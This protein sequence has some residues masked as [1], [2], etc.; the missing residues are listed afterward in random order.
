MATRCFRNLGA[1][2]DLCKNIIL[3]IIVMDGPELLQALHSRGCVLQGQDFVLK[4][5]TVSPF[6]INLRSL[7]SFPDVMSLIAHELWKHATC[8]LEEVPDFI[9]GVAH[10][11]VPI[12]TVMSTYY[13]VPMLSVQKDSKAYGASQPIEGKYS[14]GQSCIVVEDVVNT[15]SSLIRCKSTLEA[16]GIRVIKEICI[17]CRGE[18]ACSSLL[19]CGEGDG[20]IFTWRCGRTGRVIQYPTSSATSSVVTN[21]DAEGPSKML[22]D[23]I[24]KKGRL[25]VAADYRNA[26]DILS[27]ADDVGPYISVF[28]VHADTVVD[29]SEAFRNKLREKALIH[30]FFIMEDRKIADIGMI[31]R[32]QLE[33]YSWAHLVT[34]HALA[35]PS[36]FTALAPVIISKFTNIIGIV[37]VVE[38]SCKGALGDAR[39]FNLATNCAEN[40]K[41]IVAAVVAQQR[42]GSLPLMMPGV[43]TGDAHGQ[44]ARPYTDDSLNCADIVIVGRA[45]TGSENPKRACK[46]IYLHLKSLKQTF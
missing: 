1:F 10:G 18:Y 2:D 13:R 23:K 27:L 8:D 35:G 36:I 46:E 37:V 16:C 5:G 9:V 42:Y 22:R 3:D 19:C 31:A 32:M 11:A 40:A 14:R 25:C 26:K 7:V 39:Y 24:K 28:K 15:G 44:R 12:A 17:V 29:N 21:L 20:D 43:G 33:T 45:I 30:D 4:S 6:Y 38:M 34:V 41:S